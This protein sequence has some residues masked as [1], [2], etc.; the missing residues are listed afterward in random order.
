MIPK[1]NQLPAHLRN[2]NSDPK[3]AVCRVAPQHKRR[4]A[5]EKRERALRAPLHGASM[6]TVNT[7]EEFYPDYPEDC[8][9]VTEE[10][11]HDYLSPTNVTNFPSRVTFAL[12]ET[13]EQA[14]ATTPTVVR[15]A[16]LAIKDIDTELHEHANKNG[17][18]RVKQTPSATSFAR[19]PVHDR[20]ATIVPA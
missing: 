20:Y 14:M 9:D 19:S 5:A 17:V 4:Q 12:N 7:N 15:P 10:A 1:H 11:R 18:L 6:P 16:A 3:N 8:I 13:V 2:T